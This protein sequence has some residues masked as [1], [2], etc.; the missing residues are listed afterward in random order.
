MTLEERSLALIGVVDIE[1][2][3]ER[4]LSE[5]AA[6]CGAQSAA[7]WVA[8]GPAGLRLRGWRGLVDRATLPEV[9]EPSLVQATSWSAGAALLVPLRTQGRELAG[10]V[11]LADPLGASFGD[12]LLDAT[13]RLGR[14]AA[15]ALVAA[16][17]F[18]QLQRQAFADPRGGACAP[19]Y[20]NDYARRELSKARR[21]GRSFSLVTLSLDH[22]AQIRLRQGPAAARHAVELVSRV[23][24]RVLRDSDVLSRA[25]DHELQVLLPETDFFGGAQFVRRALA[26]VRA[27]PAARTLE[28]KLPLGLIGGVATFP[29][30]GEDLADL[31]ARCRERMDEGRASLGATLQ[32][33]ELRFWDQVELLLGGPGSP[34]LP[35]TAGPPSCRGLVVEGLFDDLQREIAQELLREPTARGVFFVATAAVHSELAVLRALSDAPAELAT[36]IYVLGRRADLTRHPVATTVF[37]EGEERLAQHQILLWLGEGTAYGLLQRR[38]RGTGWGFHT[39]D[40]VLVEGLVLKLQGEYDLRPY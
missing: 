33:E 2:L 16:G 22:L 36:K 7:L 5:L 32:L 13:A 30:D 27:D 40:P 39:S 34:R 4:V 11:Q 38:G 31:W 6:L 28:A 17:Q 9:L 12:E 35:L 37:L 29:R 24:G 15:A 14:F 19:A 25:G 10:L 26:A 8:A 21:Y 20:F 23:L 18:A 1:E 3:Q